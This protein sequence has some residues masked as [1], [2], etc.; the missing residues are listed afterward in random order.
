MACGCRWPSSLPIIV[1]LWPRASTRDTYRDSAARA[2]SADGGPAAQQKETPPAPGH[3]GGAVYELMGLASHS[4][5]TSSRASF[6]K[7][8]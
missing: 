3:Q 8:R 5:S 6:S 7:T 4:T 1:R 2:L